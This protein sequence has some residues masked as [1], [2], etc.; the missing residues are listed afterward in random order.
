M[1]S[2]ATDVG[3][4]LRPSGLPDLRHDT[5][6]SIDHVAVGELPQGPGF[7]ANAGAEGNADTLD[8]GDNG[9]RETGQGP[10]AFAIKAFEVIQVSRARYEQ[11]RERDEKLPAD[12]K[13]ILDEATRDRMNTQK[14]LLRTVKGP[15]DRRKGVPTTVNLQ[16]PRDRGRSGPGGQADLRIPLD[17]LRERYD[18]V[19]WK[20]FDGWARKQALSD[21]R[22]VMAWLEGAE[23]PGDTEGLASG[24]TAAFLA[25]TRAKE[26]RRLTPDELAE[27]VRS[28]PNSD[29]TAALRVWA[30]DDALFQHMK[31]ANTPEAE[32]WRKTMSGVLESIEPLEMEEPLWRGS[33]S[34][35]LLSDIRKRKAY[36][37]KRIGDSFSLDRGVSVDGYIGEGEGSFLMRLSPSRSARDMRDVF[38][39]TGGK[40]SGEAEF[41]LPQGSVFRLTEERA[42][43]FYLSR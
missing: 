36:E 13:L 10:G 32:Q 25:A 14:S 21:G 3:L 4:G 34:P 43:Y 23:T 24:L 30:E 39:V 22:T 6:I 33:Q 17:A 15:D 2:F 1:D 31:W 28:H 29:E 41:I 9:L 16:T 5:R 11:L 26:T 40:A 8:G 12:E 19:V 42:R 20:S 7:S 35:E 18:P 37:V 38:S 27:W